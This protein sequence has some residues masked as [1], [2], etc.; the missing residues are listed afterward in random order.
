MHGWLRPFMSTIFSWKRVSC[1]QPLF[2]PVQRYTC[3][4]HSLM[5]I[6]FLEWA[7]S[8]WT[9]SFP[10]RKPSLHWYVFLGLEEDPT[11]MRSGGRCSPSSLRV[12]SLLA[13]QTKLLKSC[14]DSVFLCFTFIVV[15]G[16]TLP[17][18]EGR[19]RE[20]CS[21]DTEQILQDT[22]TALINRYPDR[23]LVFWGHR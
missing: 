5:N 3:G 19:F 18:R 20:P 1:D 16:V 2:Y 10:N 7:T 13:C 14:R 23:D 4:M 17:G 12:G 8:F 9:V 11:F 6:T 22:C 21:T 15:C